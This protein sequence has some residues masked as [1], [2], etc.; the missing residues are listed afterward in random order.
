M[1]RAF[2][3]IVA[4]TLFAAGLFAF[5]AWRQPGA[6]NI[7]FAGAIV[8]AGVLFERWRYPG[9]PAKGEDGW[10]A[11]DE[12]FEDPETGQVMRVDFRPATGERRYRPLD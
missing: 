9:A 6:L 1:L 11:T 4:A 10:Q 7:A 3:L 2:L 8:F 5:T 12:R